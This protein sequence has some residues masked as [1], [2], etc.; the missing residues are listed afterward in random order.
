MIM[1]ESGQDQPQEVGEMTETGEIITT[2]PRSNTNTEP[3]LKT[4]RD[5]KD[6]NTSINIIRHLQVEDP[7]AYQ[8]EHGYY[9]M[10]GDIEI[11]KRGLS[12]D[13]QR[14]IMAGEA[15]LEEIDKDKH[16][17]RAEAIQPSA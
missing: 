3:L 13:D 11:G 9:P 1:S 8:Q 4:P 2:Q 12:P 16:T 10:P 5:Y 6:Y 15:R 7:M 14:K 17:Y